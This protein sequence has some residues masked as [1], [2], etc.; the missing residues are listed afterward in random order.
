MK[1]KIKK[2]WNESTFHTISCFCTMLCTSPLDFSIL[3]WN[4]L[5][6]TGFFNKSIKPLSM[7]VSCILVEYYIIYMIRPPQLQGDG[8]LHGKAPVHVHVNLRSIAACLAG[9]PKRRERSY[10]RAL[11]RNFSKKNK[12]K[13]SPGNKDGMILVYAD[14]HYTLRRLLFVC[15]IS[16][17]VFNTQIY[18][19]S[20]FGI[21]KQTNQSYYL[22]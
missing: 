20:H 19:T 22:H 14:S 3:L 17:I 9:D 6:I 12:E 13:I 7:I 2:V 8:S 21:C 18:V 15:W 5:K 11:Y 16:I 1:R 10:L 4:Q